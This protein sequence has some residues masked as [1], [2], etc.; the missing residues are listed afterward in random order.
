MK[1]KDSNC[2]KNDKPMTGRKN[3]AYSHSM[4]LDKTKLL[5]KQLDCTHNDFMTALLSNT[6]FEYFKKN[7]EKH[8]KI[9]VG[10]PYSMR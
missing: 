2:L 5:C 8:S 7:G 1:S 6:L 4:S 10:M 3:G 9:D